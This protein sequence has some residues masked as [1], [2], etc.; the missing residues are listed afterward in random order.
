MK[1]FLKWLLLD[2]WL[3]KQVELGKQERERLSGQTPTETSTPSQTFRS[4]EDII[5]EYKDRKKSRRRSI[6]IGIASIIITFYLIGLY[7]S[8]NNSP[9]S[10][11]PVIEEDLTNWIPS[12]FN[13]WSDDENVSWRWLKNKEYK[14]DMGEG[15]TGVMIV[16]RDGCKNSLYAEISLLDK[17]G[18]QIG[19]T[20]DTLSS[21]LSMQENKMIFNTYEKGVS[22][23]RIA[24]ISCY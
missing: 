10:P 18:V 14:C 12:G 2:W 23:V 16:A 15:C 8:P 20:N 9:A 13:S 22:E 1:K 11:Y 7:S 17:N 6:L 21:A 19:Y 4:E 3:D 24:K 5:K